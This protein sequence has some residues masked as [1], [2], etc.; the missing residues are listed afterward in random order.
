MTV[1]LEAHRLCYL[2]APKVACTSLKT[3]FFEIE[4]GFA[5]RAFRANGEWRHIHNVCYPTIRFPK[6]P[7]RRIADWTRIA[8]VRDPVERVLSAYGNRVCHHREL[9]EQAAGRRLREL[10]LPPDPDL[11]TFLDNFAAYRKAHHAVTDHLRPLTA[12]LGNEPGYFTRLYRFDDLPRLAGDV[13]AHAGCTATLPRLQ[14]EGPKFSV[15]DL[16]RRQR[17]RL[18]EVYAYD[19]RIFGDWL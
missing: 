4:N 1:F 18:R 13:A 10:G 8:V 3:M 15:G 12:F 6:L 17:E 16:S 9:S 19:Y 11:D 5:F 14:T 7:R 2:S